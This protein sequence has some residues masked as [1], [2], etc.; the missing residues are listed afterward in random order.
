MR[1]YLYLKAVESTNQWLKTKLREENLPEGFVVRTGFQE[2]GRGQGSNRWESER[3]ANLLF[4]L[5]LRPEHIAIE[6]QFILSQLIALAI[7]KTIS[8]LV[9]DEKDAFSVK[10]P[11][12][13]Y[14]NNR[15]LG[16]ILIE[17][18]VQGSVLKA[19]V[20][21]VGLNVNQ[22]SFYSD[23]PN[24]V[25]LRRITGKRHRLMNLM[26]GIR[27]HLFEYYSCDSEFIQAE[28][29]RSLY[30][31]E[32]FHPFYSDAKGRFEA[33]IVRVEADGRLV[34]NDKTGTESGFYFKEVQFVQ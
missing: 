31:R 14:W 7:L 16:G 2:A 8:I 23:A 17:N 12:D 21:G 4:S 29:A 6:K 33:E 15:K 5:L 3:G 1:Q 22:S 13:I 28:Y 24:P 26:H 19:C 20:I 9:P 10:W 30:R 11:N 25:S 18:V 27:Y 32:G 34:L